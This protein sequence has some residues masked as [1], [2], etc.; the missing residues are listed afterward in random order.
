M[1]RKNKLGFTLIE[2][3]V[4]IAIIA[5][6]AAILFPVFAK[7]REKARQTSCASNLKQLGLAVMQYVQDNDETFPCGNTGNNS[8]GTG[9]WASPIY[10][11]VKSDGLFKCP[12]DNATAT[13]SNTVVSYAMNDSLIADQNNGTGAALARLN[14]SASTV[15]F[16]EIQG[17]SG[18]I[19]AVP[20]FSPGATC[21]S[22]FWGGRPGAAAFLESKYATGN[23]P[24]QDLKLIGQKTVHTGGANYAA[25][26]GHVKY[27]MPNRIS[28]GKDNSSSAGVQNTATAEMAAGTDCMDNNPADASATNCPNS[29]TATMT[30]SKI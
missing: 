22:Q 25:T 10:P 5:I 27:L 6:L 11:Y 18:P 1:T 24:G 19:H 16:C 12:D 26:D 2:L 7:A 20:D 15:L 17:W 8:Y 30:F 4:V 14:S 28:G 3:L 21:H 29:N 23:P 9:G 13:G